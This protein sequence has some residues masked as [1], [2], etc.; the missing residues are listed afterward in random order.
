MN[1][2]VP[3]PVDRLLAP[4]SVFFAHKL[5]GAALLLG[6]AGLALLWAASPFGDS[7]R[8]ML[9]AHATVSL[10]GFVLEK[11]VHHWINDGLM[12]FFFFVVGLEL[13]REMLAG[14]LSSLRQAALPVA[15]AVGGMVV[16]AGI[17]VAVNAGLPTMAGWGVPMATDIAFA[18]GVVALLGK[19]VSPAVKLLLTAIAV[20][21]DLG[22]ILVIAVFYTSGLSLLALLVGCALALVS[23]GMNRLGVRSHLAYFLVGAAVW[24][25][26]LASGVHATLA[27]VVMAFTIPARTRLDSRGMV[28]ALGQLV[29]DYGQKA[30]PPGHGLLEPFEQDVLH[31]IEHVVEKGTAPLQRLEHALMP[32]VT[33]VVL[34]MFAFANAGVTIAGSATEV[35]GSPIVLGIG[36][37]LVVGKPLG[38][39]LAAWLAVKAG[40]RLPAGVTPRDVFGIGML[41]GIG[42]T[43]ALFIGELAFAEPALIDAAKVGT[44]VASPIAGL[45]GYWLLRRGN[46]DRNLSPPG[47]A[48]PTRPV[49][50][51]L[52]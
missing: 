42:F 25:C 19:R 6:A 1:N 41:A 30:L 47:S 22:A 50:D 34:P 2:I 23:V 49:A 35:L 3:R 15:C 46:A 51:P 33:F 11:T 13:K 17:Y 7:Y 28:D 26:F 45:L 43:M 37:G 24:L 16:P 48:L 36:L 4:L 29:H 40:L 12:A 9:H 14:E 8:G 27:A 44:L 10:G 21:D 5:A 39:S 18:L 20:A 31:E 52:Q 38:I 32:L